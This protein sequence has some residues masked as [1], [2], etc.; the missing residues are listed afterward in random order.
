MNMHSVVRLMLLAAC[1]LALHPAYA[2]VDKI[3]KPS[4][5]TKTK[6]DTAA[7]SMGEYQ[8]VKQALGVLDFTND[9]GY[10]SEWSLG[11]NMRL[12]LE[13]ALV[14]TNRFVIVERG[15]L[16][17]VLNEQ[18][19]Q[20]SKRASKSKDTAQTGR[21][22][23]ARYLASGAI[24]EASVD[25]SGEGG[26]LRIKGFRIGGS[27]AKASVVAVVKLID[28]NTGEVVA[29]ERIR[30]EAGKTTLNVAYE[31]SDLGGDL[32]A[33]AK[34]PLGEAAQNVVDQAVKILATKM[35]SFAVEGAVVAV[36]DEQIVINLGENYGV[37]GGQ[38]FIVRKAGKV[39]TDPDSGEVLD[40]IEGEVT[41]TIEVTKVREKIA[42][43][44][45]INGTLPERGDT[46][47]LH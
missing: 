43:C 31:N 5:A 45:L 1:G 27:S 12:M 11:E 7:V 8:G 32:G 34:T 3:L 6:D 25:T 36:E 33:F 2:A 18:D 41:G 42:Y 39:L 28:T 4:A 17:A 29:S 14:A 10:A 38:L 20:A 46:V 9:A 15:D 24:T 44:K 13:S 21:L 47:V 30:G 16:D 23:S 26:G 22:R 19:L 40:R 35:E 37:R